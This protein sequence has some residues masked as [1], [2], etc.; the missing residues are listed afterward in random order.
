MHFLIHVLNLGGRY[1]D[2]MTWVQDL[3][4]YKDNPRERAG[5]SQRT[6]WR[7]GYFGLIKTIGP[8]REVERDSRRQDHSDLRQARTARLAS[9]G[10]GAGVLGDT[11][12]PTRPRRRSRTCRRISTRSRAAQEPI[13]V[14]AL[15]LEATIAARDGDRKKAYDLYRKAADREA[16]LLY[17]E[18]PSYPRPVVEG[19]ANVAAATGDAR[20][21]RKRIPRGACA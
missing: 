18:P 17:T 19:W 15:E 4:T 8:L 9:L 21:G 20:D 16:T 5:N 10:D 14:A 2:S 13:L 7:Q 12:S 6:V 3:F 11:V 1:D